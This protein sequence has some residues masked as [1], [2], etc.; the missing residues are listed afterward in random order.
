MNTNRVDLIH[1]AGGAS[2]CRTLHIPRIKTDLSRREQG[3]ACIVVVIKFV[4]IFCRVNVMQDGVA[5]EELSFRAS[6]VFNTIQQRRVFREPAAHVRR[7][8]QDAAG[9]SGESQANRYHVENI[10]RSHNSLTGLL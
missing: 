4:R 6:V 7:N 5:P 1:P 9:G 2:E 8:N 3:A 10:L